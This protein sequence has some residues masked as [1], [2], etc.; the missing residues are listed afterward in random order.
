MFRFAYSLAAASAS[1][2]VL[3]ACAGTPAGLQPHALKDEAGHKGYLSHNQLA[4]LASTVPAPPAA[5][6]ATEQA[7]KA[8]SQALRQ[9]ENTDR[10][11]LATSHAEVRSPFALQH[12]DCVL[13]V[14]YD[15]AQHQAPATARVFDKLFE[16]AEAAST[17]VKRR[18][19][20]ARPVGDDASREACQTV[21]AAGRNSPSYPSGSA[22]VGAAYGAAMA[23][24][25]PEKA[26]E[27][28][29]IGRQ[30]ALS[31]AVCGMHYLTDVRVGAALGQTVF[32]QAARSPEFRADLTAAQAELAALRARGQTNP[33]CA[34]ERRALAMTQDLIL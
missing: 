10:W 23:A 21:S 24:I 19:F 6:S 15:P 34:A 9:F 25:A 1:F 33:G 31:R 20:R 30:I 22:T 3:G 18:A 7:D 29:E 16:D 17:L 4:A 13:G 8:A 11:L 5:G 2:L 14:R 32:D 28:Q 26:A 27:A 12:F